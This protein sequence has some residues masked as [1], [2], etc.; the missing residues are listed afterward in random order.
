MIVHAELLTVAKLQKQPQCP[1]TDEWI[2]KWYICNGMLLSHRTKQTNI[3]KQ[4]L[5]AAENK[6]VIPGVGVGAM[7]GQNR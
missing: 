3:R 2:K 1:S 7:D 6:L 4:R 5:M